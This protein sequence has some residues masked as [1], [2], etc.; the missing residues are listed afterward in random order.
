MWYFLVFFIVLCKVRWIFQQLHSQQCA[1]EIESLL[2]FVK[3]TC[4]NHIWKLIVCSEGWSGFC[5]FNYN[6]IIVHFVKLILT[7]NL[8][9]VWIKKKCNKRWPDEKRIFPGSRQK[10][11]YSGRVIAFCPEFVE[12]SFT[13]LLLKF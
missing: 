10:S 3:L 13:R 11:L 6:L 2:N 1:F 7:Y 4:L 9:L 5:A 12:T 8:W